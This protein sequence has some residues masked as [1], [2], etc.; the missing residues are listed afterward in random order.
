MIML[1]SHAF[2]SDCLMYP[3]SNEW[4]THAHAEPA[5]RLTQIEAN[6]EGMMQTHSPDTSAPP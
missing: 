2:P 1:P 5:D 4:D 3:D 6:R